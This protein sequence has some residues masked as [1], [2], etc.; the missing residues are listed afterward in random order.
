ME[1]KKGGDRKMIVFTAL[2][3]A[4]VVSFIVK[5]AAYHTKGILPNYWLNL[6][7]KYK[8]TW[9]IVEFNGVMD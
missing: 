1:T 3:I 5:M 8:P 7:E 2:V 9:S 6:I 4:G